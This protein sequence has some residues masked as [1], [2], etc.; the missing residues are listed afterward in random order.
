MNAKINEKYKDFNRKLNAGKRAEGKEWMYD[1]IKLE[2]ARD[3][4]EHKY[5]YI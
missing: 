1:A 2:A 4:A 3:M 5:R